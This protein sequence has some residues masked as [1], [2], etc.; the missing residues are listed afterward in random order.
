MDYALLTSVSDRNSTTTG[1]QITI[2]RHGRRIPPASPRIPTTYLPPYLSTSSLDGL[3]HLPLCTIDPIGVTYASPFPASSTSD[4]VCSFIPSIPSPPL[5]SRA[6]FFP[7]PPPPPS[8]DLSGSVALVQPY[9]TCDSLFPSLA[10]RY[11]SDFFFTRVR[12]ANVCFYIKPMGGARWM[13][14]G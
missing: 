7:P 11:C 10:V 9:T 1:F 4:P 12:S 8:C 5:I 3:Y 14:R 2:E 6:L 13:R